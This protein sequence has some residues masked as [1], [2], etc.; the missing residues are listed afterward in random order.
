[1]G[2]KLLPA[3][4]LLRSIDWREVAFNKDGAFVAIDKDGHLFRS[5][6]YGYLVSMKRM[7]KDHGNWHL[8]GYWNGITVLK[9][10]IPYA[11]IE[12]ESDD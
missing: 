5:D 3:N 8:V 2:T 9:A 6:E 11:Y 4:P 7:P 1:M 12:D 10:E